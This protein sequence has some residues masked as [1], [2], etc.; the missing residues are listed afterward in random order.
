MALCR[1]STR[2]WRYLQLQTLTPNVR[3]VLTTEKLWHYDNAPAVS[4]CAS[5]QRARHFR[6]PRSDVA[7]LDDLDME[8]APAVNGI[9]DNS[10]GYLGVSQRPNCTTMPPL[11]QRNRPLQSTPRVESTTGAVM[12]GTSQLFPP[13][14]PGGVAIEVP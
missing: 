3:S 11:M 9:S 6:Y 12:V 13:L 2:L 5:R 1:R 14:S 8:A 4:R 10:P 7:S